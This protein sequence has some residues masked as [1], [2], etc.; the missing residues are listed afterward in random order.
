MGT[1]LV[2]RLA[3]NRKIRSDNRP[4]SRS[5]DIFIDTNTRSLAHRSSGAAA[6]SQTR[7]RFGSCRILAAFAAV[8]GMVAVQQVA[9]AQAVDILVLRLSLSLTEN[10]G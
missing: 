1:L 7:R 6:E 8:I 4:T 9:A 2:V 10:C 5:L 3:A